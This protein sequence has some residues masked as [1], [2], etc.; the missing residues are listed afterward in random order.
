MAP[1]P[2]YSVR[3]AFFAL[4]VLALTGPAAW[5]AEPPPI[6]RDC[7]SCHDSH[8]MPPGGLLGATISELCRGCHAV[9]AEAEHLVDVVPTMMVLGLPLDVEGRMTCIT[10]HDPHGKT[11]IPGMLRDWPEALCQRCHKK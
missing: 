10:C 3:W 7:G 1:G 6:K 9:K 8:N 2:A 4:L 11:G 5:A